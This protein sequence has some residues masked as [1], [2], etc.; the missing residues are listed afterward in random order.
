L[1]R[2]SLTLYERGAAAAEPAKAAAVSTAETRMSENRFMA[3][4]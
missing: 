2:A 3:R 4:K 1:Q